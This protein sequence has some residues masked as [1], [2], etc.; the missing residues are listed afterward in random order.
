MKL[1]PWQ[2]NIIEKL[3]ILFAQ[4]NAKEN[5]IAAIQCL[6]TTAS[7]YILFTKTSK[8]DQN[9]ISLEALSDEDL[10]TL[11]NEGTKKFKKQSL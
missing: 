11:I 5:I 2:E 9:K 8:N 3:D 4:A 1:L 6:K 10:K 7:L